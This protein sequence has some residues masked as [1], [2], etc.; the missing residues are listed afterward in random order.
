[1][2]ILSRKDGQTIRGKTAAGEKFK[3]SVSKDSSGQIRVAIE[4][5]KSIKFARDE[6]PEL[7]PVAPTVADVQSE[8]RAA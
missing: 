7:E 5:P 6:L 4:A 8:P 3:F 2:L 1:M